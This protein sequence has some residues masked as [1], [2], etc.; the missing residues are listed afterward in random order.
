MMQLFCRM[1]NRL[2]SVVIPSPEYFC[3]VVVFPAP[4]TLHDVPKFCLLKNVPDIPKYQIGSLEVKLYPGSVYC[5][6][7]SKDKS[8]GSLSVYQYKPSFLDSYTYC[9]EINPKSVVFQDAVKEEDSFTYN[10][11]DAS[12]GSCPTSKTDGSD[13][14]YPATGSTANSK[15]AGCFNSHFPSPNMSKC[16][17][18]RMNVRMRSTK[19]MPFRVR[20]GALTD[21]DSP[22]I[23]KAV[24]NAKAHGI[25][26]HV[27]VLNLGNGNC[28]FESIIDSINTRN[29]FEE[30]IDDTPDDL[31]R[32]W[33]EEVEKIA[34]E[35]WNYGFTR[36]EWKTEWS[37]LKSSRTYECKLGDLVLPGVAHCVKK[38]VLI[39][40]TSPKAHSPVYFV[41]SSKLA[42][43]A[44]NTEAPI[45]LAYDQAHY[46]PL[47]P[48]TNDDVLKTIQLK[49]AF[50]QGNY[51]KQMYD[52]PILKKLCMEA[53]ISY[54]SVVIKGRGK[55]QESVTNSKISHQEFQERSN[56][57]QT[58]SLY[59]TPK[60]V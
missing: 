14:S 28:I 59:K 52:I 50:I 41:P 44:N 5:L 56:S 30:T 37:A 7:P 19:I 60:K 35:E 48:D 23:K 26:I 33:L 27:G 24:E 6:L 57:Q 43:Q 32:I 9:Q 40:N 58:L 49:Q 31:R 20:G 54:A 17:W 15:C 1:E 4:A 2:P 47:V 42:G 39:F 51:E 53:S 8:K 38:D 21:P 10:R 22:I 25:D 12:E 34:Y 55:C 13:V 45:C 36:D 16:K 18:S 11:R 46:E 3:N 29:C